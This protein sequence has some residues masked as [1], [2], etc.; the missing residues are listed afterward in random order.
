ML[1]FACPSCGNPVSAPVECAGRWTR[2]PK[3]GQPIHVPLPKPPSSSKMAKPPSS[4]GIVHKPAAK[5]PTP[6]PRTKRGP[7][8]QPPRDSVQAGKSSGRL[9][10]AP[11]LT[12]P[13]RSLGARMAAFAVVVLAV[14]AAG[15]TAGYVVFRY[16]GATAD[17]GESRTKSSADAAGEL[18]QAAGARPVLTSE[19]ESRDGTGRPA[20]GAPSPTAA[21]PAPTPQKVKSPPLEQQKTPD[22]VDAPKPM[23]KEQPRS[24]DLPLT[25]ASPPPLGEPPPKPAALPTEEVAPKTPPPAVAKEEPKPIDVPKPPTLD[26][27]IGGTTKEAVVVKRLKDLSDEDLRKQLLAAPDVG[28]GQGDAAVLYAPL[29]A[30]QRQGQS[31]PALPADYGPHF[32]GELAVKTRRPEL[33]YFPWH[34]GPD[35][36]LGKE[37]AERLHVLSLNLRTCLRSAAPQ[38]DIRPDSDNLRVLM[39]QGRLPGQNF[40]VGVNAGEIKPSEWQQPGAIPALMQM[41]QTENTPVRLLLVDLL[42]QMEGKEASA[43]LARRRCSTSPR[44]CGR[45]RCRPWRIVRRRTMSRCCWTAS[46]TRGRRRRTTRQRPLSPSR[47]GTP[48]PASSPC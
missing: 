26:S 42:S 32:L 35:C 12:Y 13:R 33:T 31:P 28:L 20:D 36:Q 18:A 40:I 17:L 8:P 25:S 1:R 46:A 11:Q 7:A 44:K 38:G 5:L 21:E 4:S 29:V 9:R 34:K 47:T 39:L 45:R 37:T 10:P 27:T 48:C 41:L 6:A 3:C 24:A 14:F 16:L 19:V 22:A 15:G 2:C 23:P 30:F 43:A